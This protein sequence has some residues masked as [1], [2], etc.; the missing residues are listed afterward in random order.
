[1]AGLAGAAGIGAGGGDMLITMLQ[2]KL[3]QEQVGRR[4]QV[5]EA[6]YGLSVNSF[7]E[8]NVVNFVSLIFKAH[9]R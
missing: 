8:S 3:E 1:M 9:Y 6:W 7:C 4:D 2:R 5:A